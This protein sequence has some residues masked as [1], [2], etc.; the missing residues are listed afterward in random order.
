MLQMETPAQTGQPLEHPLAAEWERLTLLCHCLQQARSSQEIAQENL[1]RLQHLQQKVAQQRGPEGAWGQHLRQG[2]S[3]VELDIVV[4]AIAAEIEPR[5]ALAFQAL[6]LGAA[7]PYPTR[8]LIQELLALLPHQSWWL[9]HA[10]APYSPLRR[11]RWVVQEE[12]GP[13]AAIKPGP[14]VVAYLLGG[15]VLQIP[16]PGSTLVEMQAAWDD[17][18]LPP[19]RK[20]MLQEFGFWIRYRSVVEGEWEGVRSGGP[21]ALFTGPSGTG[22]TFAA[23][24]LAHE[25]EWPLYRVDLGRLV[26]KYIGETEKNLNAL[27]DAADGQPMVLQFDEA[28]SVFGKRGEIKEA[29]DRYANMEVNHLLARIENHRGPCILTTN[30]G[31]QIDTAFQR[32]FQMVVSFP[33]PDVAARKELWQRLLPSKAPRAETLDLQFLAEAVSLSGGSIRNAALHAAYL[34]AAEE[35][36][37]GLAQIAVGVWRELSKEHREV[38]RRELGLLAAHLPSDITG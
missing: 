36:E 9:E 26:S 21:V 37:I 34:A 3:E 13:F 8:M 23:A 29:R 14:G 30:L 33:R 2:F 19:D 22:K 1:D 11:H 10:L 12:E 38:K 27:F 15:H 4:C 24:V 17:L 5:V 25:L 31:Q 16:P 28:D 6:Q 32:R 18:I 20:R 7:Q 35:T